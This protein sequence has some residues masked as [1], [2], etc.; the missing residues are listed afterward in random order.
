MTSDPYAEWRRYLHVPEPFAEVPALRSW[1]RDW[2]EL[3]LAGFVLAV[4]LGIFPVGVSFREVEG[5][6]FKS[7]LVGERLISAVE[8]LV[9][10]G[11]LQGRDDGNE[12]RWRHMRVEQ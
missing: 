7:G 10:A 2:T 8:M 5:A 9:Y 12:V 1:L 6:H 3:D 4:T 11:V